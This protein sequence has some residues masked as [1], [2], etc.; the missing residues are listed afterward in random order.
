MKKT[1]KIEYKLVREADGDVENIELQTYGEVIQTSDTTVLHF[2]EDFEEGMDVETSVIIEGNDF[3]EV[4]RKGTVNMAQ[5]LELG[6][7]TEGFYSVEFGVMELK[8]ITHEMEVS[9]GNI[10]IKYTLFI[11]ETKMGLY[12]ILIK[13][14]EDGIN[15]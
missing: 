9:E 2:V 1:H 4:I 10:K 14:A 11:D 15:D 8:T 6:K 3:A 5:K 12:T 13:Y 7:T